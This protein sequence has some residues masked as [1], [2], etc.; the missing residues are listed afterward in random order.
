[1]RLVFE[2]CVAGVESALAAQ[3][4]GADRVELCADLT[5]GGVTP[6]A[7]VIAVVCRRL[8]IPLHVLIR[9]RELD[10]LYSELEF[11]AMR[12]DVD[13]AKTLGAAG[14][15][16]GLL[17]PHGSIDRER[18][19]RLIEAA[20]PLS[21]T[22]HKAFDAVRDQDQALELLIALGVER[23][24]TSGGAPTVRA[25]LPRLAE[26]VRISA[27]RIVIMAGGQIHAEDLFQ[28][29]TAHVREVH[30]GSAL[31]TGPVTD[32]EKVR[33]FAQAARVAAESA[34]RGGA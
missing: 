32:V 11:D 8:E 19:A 1:M 33:R 34:Q 7:G 28:I 23:I 4:G 21:V 20:R 2:A 3:E 15:V 17:T 6:S 9:P 30:A 16:L 18:T 13:T 14:I 26:L 24:L 27:G 31:R 5:A 25:G 12:H 22:F 10:F 29:A